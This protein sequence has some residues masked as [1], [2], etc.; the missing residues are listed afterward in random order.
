MCEQVNVHSYVVVFS[1]LEASKSVA[2]DEFVCFKHLREGQKERTG[3][4]MSI[5][6]P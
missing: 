4:L 2:T 3:F 5:A 6:G 1:L